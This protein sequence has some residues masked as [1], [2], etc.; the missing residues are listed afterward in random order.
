MGKIYAWM[1][2]RYLLTIK[3]LFRTEI[4]LKVGL[5]F[6]LSI[7]RYFF[8]GFGAGHDAEAL[9]GGYG[10][11][12]ENIGIGGAYGDE[13]Q[14]GVN[15]MRGGYGSELGGGVNG[16]GEGYEVGVGNGK[17]NSTAFEHNK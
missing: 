1:C 11:G 5:Y 15:G 10:S 2:W 8:L 3:S 16:I 14:N 12:A 7:E 6:S 17:K 9:G 13:A 4:N